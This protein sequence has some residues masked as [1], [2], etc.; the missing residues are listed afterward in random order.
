M[1]VISVISSVS[2]VEYFF[3][4]GCCT[5]FLTQIKNQWHNRIFKHEL[6]CRGLLQIIELIEVST[7]NLCNGATVSV[8]KPTKVCGQTHMGVSLI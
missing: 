8:L 5:F 1:S 6:P 7:F 3:S 2:D 4:S